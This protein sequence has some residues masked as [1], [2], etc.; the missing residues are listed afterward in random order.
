VENIVY[1]VV[2]AYDLTA[3]EADDLRQSVPPPGFA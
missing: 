1:A 2:A 3:A